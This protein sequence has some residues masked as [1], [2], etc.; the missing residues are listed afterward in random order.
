MSS[1]LKS[2][3]L[4]KVKTGQQDGGVEEWRGQKERASENAQ[5]VNHSLTLLTCIII[6]VQIDIHLISIYRRLTL[7]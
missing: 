5:L 4:I 6:E 1:L 3:S 2:H 7:D